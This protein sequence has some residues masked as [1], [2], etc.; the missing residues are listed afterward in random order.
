MATK[1]RGGL[2]PVVNGFVNETKRKRQR[3]V[4]FESSI[5][6]KEEADKSHRGPEVRRERREQNKRLKMVR[7]QRLNDIYL[8]VKTTNPAMLARLIAFYN[9]NNEFR[10]FLNSLIGRNQPAQATLQGSLD[11]FR[12][13]T[14]GMTYD[15]LSPQQQQQIQ[16]LSVHDGFSAAFMDSIS[17]DVVTDLSGSSD[18]GS[19]SEA[20]KGKPSATKKTAAKK[21]A[22]HKKKKAG[23]AKKKKKAYQK[24]EH[25]VKNVNRRRGGGPPPPGGQGGANLVV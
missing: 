3:Q 10:F 20:G 7:Q 11:A 19:D 4:H 21:E 18:N 16:Y 1:S 23:A 15:Q 17:A 13:A 25:F 9:T 2:T 12:N 24:M 22:K 6:W 8:L 14:A 5:N